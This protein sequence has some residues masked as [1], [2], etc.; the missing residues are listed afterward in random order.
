MSLKN[1]T[2]FKEIS[3]S[4]KFQICGLIVFVFIFFVSSIQAQEIKTTDA[5][6]QDIKLEQVFSLPNPGKYSVA[7]RQNGEG[8]SI[9]IFN[10]N[11]LT[12]VD[13]Q[14]NTN[15]QK[16]Y[17]KDVDII[18]LPSGNVLV[19]KGIDEDRANIWLEDKNGNKLRDITKED[20]VNQIGSWLCANDGSWLM[21]FASGAQKLKILV[22]GSDGNLISTQPTSIGWFTD[23]S[24]SEDNNM[25]GIVCSWSK[26]FYLLDKKGNL[27][28]QFPIDDRGAACKFLNDNKHVCFASR[29]SIYYMD[30]NTF[31]TDEISIPKP[32][33]FPFRI[34][35]FK[36]GNLVLVTGTKIF[37]VDPTKNEL[38][39]LLENTENYFGAATSLGNYVVISSRS[40]VAD[41]QDKKDYLSL[42]NEK[43]QT[44]FKQ[45]L[46]AFAHDLKTVGDYLIV[47]IPETKQL[48]GKSEIKIFK[49]SNTP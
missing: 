3:K 25:V 14:K 42:I 27:I 37:I 2:L 9:R 44:V 11:K 39:P 13:D 15:V 34:N 49:F 26:Y 43:G 8:F 16:T 12:E 1:Q 4:V 6:P 47:D 21:L 18:P 48:S 23:S 46:P 35:E 7:S 38:T 19:S 31:K 17:P 41:S 36:N 22:Y 20:G 32:V 29:S 30:V 33:A 28:Q 24:V 45:E 40:E 5:Q 10:D